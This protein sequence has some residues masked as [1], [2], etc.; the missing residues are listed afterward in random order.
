[1]KCLFTFVGLLVC[2]I[3]VGGE[4]VRV[5]ATPSRA[6]VF[7][8]D[9]ALGSSMDILA[10][11]QIDK[12]YSKE[13][14]QEAL[15]AGWGP[16]T[17]RQNT[18]LSIGA[19]HWNPNGTWSN[20]ANSSGYFVGSTELKDPIRHSFG[21]SLPHRGM[22]RTDWSED[23]YARMTDGDEATCW[24]SN[25]YLSK[26]FT[27]ED[28][29]LLPQ[30]I[31]VNF[32]IPQM[33]SA[34]RIAWGNP[35]ATRYAVQYWTGKD[36][37]DEP[38]SGKWVSFAS[39]DVT[40]GKGDTATLKLSASPVKTQYLRIWMTQS[41]NT[42]DTRGKDDVRNCL[43]YA[44]NEIYA[45]NWT[46]NG[47]FVD[48]VTHA[49]SQNQTATYV[50]STDPWHSSTD[51]VSSRVQTGMDLFF[52]SGITNNLPAM[53]PVSVIYST[54]EDAAAQITYLK[55]RNYPISYIEIGEEPDGKKTPPEN[56]AAL[57][58]QWASALHK[59]DPTLKLGGPIFE[60]VLEDIE[61]WP[62]ATGKTSW[63]GR[64][65]DYLKARGRM[66]DLAFV[67]FEHYPFEPCDMNWSDLYGEAEKTKHILQVWRD[68]GVP[69]NVPLMNTESNI[70]WDLS[71]YM[72]ELISALWLTDSVGSFL[73]YG[74]PGAVYYHS[75]IQPEPL[76][77]G[78]RGYST[79][80]NFVADEKLN[81]SQYTAQY[82]ASQMI[83]FE[84][85]KHGAGNHELYSAKADVKDD[86]G[87]TLITAYP[88]K[89]PG[90]EWS[91]IIINKDP[92]NPHSVQIQ[93]VED[94]VPTREFT[95]NLNS[96]TFGPEQYAWHSQGAKSHA[97][98]DG[99]PLTSTLKATKGQS[100]LLPRASITILRG[101][102][103]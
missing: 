7:D 94:S 95:G 72:T 13:M 89:Q 65:I 26:N 45:G 76:R 37:F 64:F 90:G 68:D 12:V 24:K 14:I 88:V 71:E 44:V 69:M 85:V 17:Y 2:T 29:A 39:G 77:Q 33:I 92:S 38:K 58:I 62:N 28:D 41:S 25:P 54:P 15:S 83:N 30:W 1:M 84:W 18:E 100:F 21:Y 46:T 73:T 35:Y 66:N 52:T 103:E 87:N 23:Q 78:C 63:M 80:G 3:A 55:K 97:D 74:G 36:P 47:E 40:E 51:I 49:P 10:A 60:S 8:P 5:D 70:T 31:V 79:Y 48:L 56:Y 11:D 91:V 61:V 22:T 16:I 59:V 27:G 75:P 34:I 9:K 57:Y 102:I 53:I 93:F 20:P 96:V 6:I 4:I 101:K 98:P 82:F 32:D 43:G 67:S 42:C 50:S 99:P 81:I 19:W 86:A